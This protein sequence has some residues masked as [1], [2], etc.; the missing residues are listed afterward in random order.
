[1]MEVA[2]FVAIVLSNSEHRAPDWPVFVGIVLLLF[3]NPS[4][5]VY[6]ERKAG[7]AVKSIMDSLAPK[8]DSEVKRD[9]NRSEIESSDLNPG[10]VISFKIGDI[11]RK[12]S[13]CLNRWHGLRLSTPQIEA[14]DRLPVPRCIPAYLGLYSHMWNRHKSYQ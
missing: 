1:M 8:A 10:D 14:C 7:N 13:I 11:S 2:A 3:V 6:R 9:G 4:I 5:S 12:P